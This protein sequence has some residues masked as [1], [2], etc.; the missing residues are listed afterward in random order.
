MLNY[1]EKYLKYKEKYFLLKKQQHGGMIQN[2]NLVIDVQNC[3]MM[4]GSFIAKNKTGDDNVNYHPVTSSTESDININLEQ[5]NEILGLIENKEGYT[6]LTRDFHPYGHASIASFDKTPD[7]PNTWTSHCVDR[8]TVCHRLEYNDSNTYMV[9]DDTNRTSQMLSQYID[10]KFQ[11]LDNKY[12]NIV[13]K[14]N[15]IS[16]MYY[17]ADKKYKNTVALNIL[18]NQNL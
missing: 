10:S 8:D 1:H 7:P 11:I 3:F 17:I 6:V 9:K 12:E 13:I 18:F 16:A 2:I 15:E 5:I 4:G 14:G